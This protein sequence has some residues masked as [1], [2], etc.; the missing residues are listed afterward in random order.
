MLKIC[1]YPKLL[2]WNITYLT[3]LL[4][5]PKIL[6]IN[7]KQIEKNKV[8]NNPCLDILNQNQEIYSNIEK[9]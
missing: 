2:F 5:L 9:R 8:I 1:S 4:Y 7:T 6:I 3:I